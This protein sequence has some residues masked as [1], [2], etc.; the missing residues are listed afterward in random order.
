MTSV[1]ACV[2]RGHHGDEVNQLL[3]LVVVEAKRIIKQGLD[4]MEDKQRG[5]CQISKFLVGNS[6]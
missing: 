2:I 3:H 4:Y 1:F 5:L 6:G